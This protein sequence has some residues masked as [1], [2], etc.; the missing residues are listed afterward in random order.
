MGL[1]TSHR[2]TRATEA[3]GGTPSVAQRSSRRVPLNYVPLNRRP[4]F[5]QLS[6]CT[7]GRSLGFIQVCT[8]PNTCSTQARQFPKHHAPLILN[9]LAPSLALGPA[10][11]TPDSFQHSKPEY[12]HSKYVAILTLLMAPLHL[13]VGSF[14]NG[15]AEVFRPRDGVLDLGSAMLGDAAARAVA[16]AGPNQRLFHGR[17]I[18]LDIPGRQKYVNNWP[19]GLFL[20]SWAVM[21]CTF[22]VQV[23]LTAK[24]SCRVFWNA[25]WS[26][27]ARTFR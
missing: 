7:R 22:K 12:S 15:L 16:G 8:H 6:L 9:P 23:R 21:L 14:Q 5:I 10:K 19:F 11:I 4:S 1:R 2:R 17:P 26:F 25:V 27:I 3:V 18:S 13:Q 24:L 20:R